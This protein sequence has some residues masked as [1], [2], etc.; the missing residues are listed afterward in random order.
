[1]YLLCFLEIV[2]SWVARSADGLQDVY[3]VQAGST[4]D[5]ILTRLLLVQ[6]VSKR[7]DGDAQS[8]A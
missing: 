7:R 6:A 1:M 3:E 8:E 4:D 5:L 2:V